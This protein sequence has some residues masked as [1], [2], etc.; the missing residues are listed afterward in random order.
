MPDNAIIAGCAFA[1]QLADRQAKHMRQIFERI[2]VD[3]VG[4][5]GQEG[6]E[7]C[8]VV[9]ADNGAGVRFRQA[10]LPQDRQDGGAGIRAC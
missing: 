8:A 3:I 4:A 7:R 6:A 2:D 1:D 10:V 5:A 9:F